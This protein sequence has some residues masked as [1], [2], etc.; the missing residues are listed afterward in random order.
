MITVG[1]AILHKL[2]RVTIHM[3][4]RG[5]RVPTMLCVVGDYIHTPQA[6]SALAANA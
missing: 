5:F 6:T 1:A 2:H 3:L 4:T